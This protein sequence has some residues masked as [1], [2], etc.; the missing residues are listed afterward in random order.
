MLQLFHLSVVKVNLDIGLLSEEEKARAGAMH[1][2]VDVGRRHRPRSAD[3]EE[4]G[5][6]SER[7]GRGGREAVWKR[8]ARHWCGETG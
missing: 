5:E 2:G 3:V 7:R 1:G 4:A 8:R 6:S